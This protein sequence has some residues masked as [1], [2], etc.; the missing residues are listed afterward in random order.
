LSA[1]R[2]LPRG[3]C[4]VRCKES[5][6]HSKLSQQ[7]QHQCR[8][9]QSAYGVP[10]GG[11]AAHCIWLHYSWASTHEQPAR[12]YWAYKETS[13]DCESCLNTDCNSSSVYSWF[14]SIWSCWSQWFSSSFTSQLKFADI[15]RDQAGDETLFSTCNEVRDL[16]TT[17][18]SIYTHEPAALEKLPWNEDDDNIQDIRAISIQSQKVLIRKV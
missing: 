9:L 18:R 12:T 16:R 5:S 8:L 15:L 14:N 3:I 7:E 11:P 4:I 2:S 6:A 10:R 1:S 13:I 17:T